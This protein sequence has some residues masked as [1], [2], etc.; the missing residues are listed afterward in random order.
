MVF[1]DLLKTGTPHQKVLFSVIVMC[2]HHLYNFF[3]KI[4]NNWCEENGKTKYDNFVFKCTI[5]RQT[6]TKRIDF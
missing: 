3:T 2:T 5:R 1:E 6:K 4:Y